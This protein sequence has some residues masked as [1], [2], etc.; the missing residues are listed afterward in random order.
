MTLPRQRTLGLILVSVG[1][2]GLIATVWASAASPAPSRSRLFPVRGPY[3]RAH[4][5]QACTAPQLPGQTVDVVLSDMGGMM[6]G[7]HM[8]SVTPNPSTVASGEVSL[9]VWNSGM[10]VH[11]LVVLPL[12]A[13]GTGTQSVG[14]RRPSERGRQ[15]RRGFQILRR[16]IRRRHCPRCDGLGHP[17]SRSRSIRAHLQS[18][19]TLRRGHVRR[20]R[21]LVTQIVV[22]RPLRSRRYPARGRKTRGNDR[23]QPRTETAGQQPFATPAA[24]HEIG[25]DHALKVEARFQIPLGLRN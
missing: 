10:M 22:R 11:E 8:M 6:T 2:V 21:R 19:W 4:Q 13:G 9:R 12:P 23:K 7:G 1:F 14:V 16:R 5:G 20:A 15:T 18:A 17:A 3:M 25:P 24:G